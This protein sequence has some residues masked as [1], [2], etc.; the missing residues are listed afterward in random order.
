PCAEVS[1]RSRPVKL[2]GRGVRPIIAAVRRDPG[3]GSTT[4]RTGDPSSGKGGDPPS[5]LQGTEPDGDLG[6]PGAGGL[7]ELVGV[8]GVVAEQ[9]EEGPERGVVGSPCATAAPRPGRV[10]PELGD[11]G[12][13]IVELEKGHGAVADQPVGAPALG[14]E[15]RP[16]DGEHL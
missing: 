10:Q 9:L 12:R 7:G 3:P 4:S 5:E 6:G 15:H 11:G 14:A 13:E 1:P 8:E 16:G 2:A